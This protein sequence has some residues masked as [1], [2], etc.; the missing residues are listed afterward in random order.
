MSNAEVR[1]M[2]NAVQKSHEGFIKEAL[3]G[4]GTGR[5]ARRRY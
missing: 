2:I 4:E 1:L 5:L 3:I